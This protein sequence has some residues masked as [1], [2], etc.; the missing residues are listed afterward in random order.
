MNT[1][2]LPDMLERME[3]AFASLFA[4]VV[5]DRPLDHAYTYAVPDHLRDQVAV[6]KRIEAPFGRGDK[7]IEGYVIRVSANEPVRE[8]KSIT[9]VVDDVALLDEHLLKLT[10]WMA[11]YYL[12]GWGQVLHAVVP[13]GVRENAGTKAVVFVEA[14]AKADLPNPLPSVTPKQKLALDRLK[15]EGQAMELNQ[16]A[17]IVGSGTSPISGLVSKGLVRKYSER[18]DKFDLDYLAQKSGTDAEPHVPS[19]PWVL[20]ADQQRAWDVIHGAL[21]VGRHQSFLLHGVTGSGKTEIY[22]KALEEVVRQGKEAIVLVPEISLTPQTIERFRGRS[23]AVAVLHSNLT[24]AERGGYW[25]R[26]AAG[27]TQVVVGARSA[28][29]APTRKLGLIIIDEEHENSF[30]QESTPRYHARDVAVMRAALADVPII[31]GSATPSLESWHQASTGAYTLLT[32]PNRVENRPLPAVRLV[33][34][35]HEPKSPGKQFAIGQT[36]ETA[37]RKALKDGGQVMLL[38][39]RRGYS[40]HVHCPSCGHVAQCQH[41]DLSLTFHRNKASLVCHYCGWETAPLL[42]CPQCAQS[43]I[44]YQGLGTEKLQA[45]L[46]ER[47]PAQVIQRMDSDTMSKPGSHQRVLDAFRDGLIHILLGTQ[48]IAKGLDFPNVTLVGVINADVGLHLPDFR[49]AE[50]TFQLLTQVAG[51]SGRG[52]KGG[53]VMVQTFTPEH[54]SIALAAKHNFIEFAK[55][56]MTHRKQHG[57][58]PYHRMARLIVRSEK[59]DGASKFADQ[60]AG[61]FREAVVRASRQQNQTAPTVR[62]LGPAECPVFKLNDYYRFHFQLQSEKSGDLHQVLR[63]VLAVS[64]PPSG[65][66]YQVDV[67]PFSML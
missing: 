10:R 18:I 36:L 17:R 25:R 1:A 48:M 19:T 2:T 16:L 23:G 52:D 53:T 44:R 46:E 40:T 41:C 15:K 45:E 27:H 57:Y 32:L 9:K 4:D 61:A 35:R 31:L 64:K 30:K 7:T 24:D 13:A 11:D 50:R 37:M 62:V 42:K 6:G 51:R 65:V 33:D 26:I 66:E 39:N 63:E 54:P 56:E 67:D 14:V 29:F 34:L 21:Q 22:L 3:P 43:A 28:V 20:N 47:F 5:F 59:E 12:A 8:V 60:L 49:A 55:L 38:L 58:P